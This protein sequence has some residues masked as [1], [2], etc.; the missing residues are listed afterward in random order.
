MKLL[1]KIITGLIANCVII[2]ALLFAGSGDFEWKEGWIFLIAYMIMLISFLL[3][4][5][6]NRK[7]LEERMK[8]PIQKNQNRTDK[9]IVAFL[10][11]FLYG[12]LVIMPLEHRYEWTGIFPIWLV[13]IGV[14]GFF[15][16]AILLYYTA[17]QN[18]FLVMTVK[19]QE[20]HKVISDG[21]YSVVRHPM[22]MSVT[23][24]LFSGA[25]ILSSVYG[26]LCALGGMIVF[27][28]RILFEEKLLEKE[29]EGYTEY[30]KKVKY[31]LIP[32]LI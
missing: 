7:L 16:S 21:L 5:R 1:L 26:L 22:Y 20:D 8:S 12:W 19:K 32:F 3:P 17:K 15:I 25:L 10:M 6:K 2:G 27:Y 13:G 31:R 4:M 30:K 14:I 18:A 23:L 9:I 24:T 11:L 28:I 29:L